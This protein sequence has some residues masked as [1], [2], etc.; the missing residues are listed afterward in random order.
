[1]KNNHPVVTVIIPTH[2]R[3]HLI[4]GSI[5]SVL[6]QTFK[7]FELIIVDDA[8]ND[9]I[10][11]VVNG[12]KD[13]R[14]KYIHHDK[15]Q[16]GPTARNTGIKAAKGAYIAL[17]DDDDQWWPTKLEEQVNKFN[18]VSNKV[19]LVYS[20]LE[21]RRLTGDSVV[22]TYH[23]QFRG[24]LRLRLLLGTTIGSPTPLIKR[25]CFEKVGLFDPRLKSCQDWDMWKRI[26]EYYEFVQRLERSA[27][28]INCSP[29]I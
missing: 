28:K 13:D 17:L 3:A 2:N 9:N 5:R 19:G 29:A 23:P 7:N 22:R 10:S 6:D 4:S 18:E 25:E 14:I 27:G 24:D 26:S 8:S 20:G 21:V 1:M 15:N 12:F 11:E 16:G